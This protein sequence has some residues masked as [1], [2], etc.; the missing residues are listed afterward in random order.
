MTDKDIPDIVV[1][2]LP[3]YLQAL[4][5]MLREGYQIT[6]SQELGEQIGISAA[7][8]RKD[9]SQFGEFGKQG[10]G[11]SIPYLVRELQKILKV[12]R[13]WPMAL[14]GAGNL[15][16]AIAN[17]P[18]FGQ[19]GFRI[20]VI[21]DNDPAHIG[22]QIGLF[23]VLDSSRIV[24]VL[25]AQ[26]IVIAM[27]TVPALA[28]QSATDQLVEAGVR[29]IVNYAPIPLTVPGNVHVQY[30]DPIVYLQRM[31]YYLE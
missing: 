30:I 7:Q 3:R 27:L 6:S 19:H 14:V 20:A 1:G 24:S 29:A 11:Y 25:R 4:E 26:K 21:F 10:K 12:D 22:T 16:H 8:I 13:I 2:R 23:T 28:A 17:Y 31:T 9:L 18:G 15:G 5:H